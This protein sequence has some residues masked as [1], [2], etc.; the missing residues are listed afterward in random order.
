LFEISFKYR[1]RESRIF[2]SVKRPLIDIEIF[3]EIDKK[4]YLVEDI[5]ADSGADI[6]V[7]PYN[8]SQL[9]IKDIESGEETEL[10]GIV[11]YVK[12]TAYLHKMK[13]KLNNNEFIA[14]VAIAESDDVP[15]ILGREKA[16]NLFLFEFNKGKELKIKH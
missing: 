3:S 14:P 5:L 16:I 6:S 9:F 15:P 11:P 12:I 7:F 8:Q 1:E 4:W 2:G 13:F 10:M